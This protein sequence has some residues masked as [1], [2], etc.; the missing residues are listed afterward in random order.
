MIT[1]VGLIYLLIFL[2]VLSH[3]LAILQ[4]KDYW[5]GRILADP[6]VWQPHPS[7][8]L[9]VLTG[10]LLLW[11]RV[12]QIPIIATA[13]GLFL[14]LLIVQKLLTRQF[15]RPKPT[16]RIGLVASLVGLLTG[17]GYAISGNNPGS[18][19]IATGVCLWFVV[20]ANEVARHIVYIGHRRALSR[21]AKA[22]YS[23]PNIKVVGITGSFGKSTTKEFLNTILGQSHHYISTPGSINTD[24]GLATSLNQQF[25]ML[26]PH[27]KQQT[28]FAV[29]EMD[30]YVV[31][32]LARVTQYFPLDLGLITAINEQHLDTFGG[33]IAN[34]VEGNFQM[35]VG[36]NRSQPSLAVFNFDNEYCRAMADRFVNELQGEVYSYG[37]VGANL[38]VRVSEVKSIIAPGKQS[39][40]FKLEFSKRLGGEFISLELPVPN[41]F[42][43]VNYAAAALLAKLL[44]VN[45]ADIKA[46]ASK[47]TVKDRTQK[48]WLTS[49]GIEIIDDTFN[50][51]P[52]SVRANLE[53]LKQ[54]N[55]I[56]PARN[57]V[58]FT[59]LYD[60]GP[61]A[62]EIHQELGNRLEQVADVA[63]LTN[64]VWGEQ[65]K[66]GN[67]S[68][69]KLIVN[70][71][72][73][74]LLSDL[75]KELAKTTSANLPKLRI[76]MI[77]RIPAAVYKFIK[78]LN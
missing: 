28:E 22:L 68:S 12:P 46:A 76:L 30:A 74:S 64:P 50:A 7:D 33:D 62:K 9:L 60:L 55:E 48:I 13:I 21:A 25:A 47:V 75:Q 19:A 77:N 17:L 6:R 65:L 37:R 72:P 38:D 20:I 1:I 11:D 59:G 53:L 71:N 78:Q 54:R 18:L 67:A 35:L 61:K 39:L 52:A 10:L 32:T 15:K 31:G 3:K 23:I 34:T 29:L 41:E 51:N 49:S 57:I 5:R 26:K 63:Y 69:K 40:Q 70:S 14:L 8:I 27:E 16:L 24:I 44:G 58:I 45:N 73:D 66:V 2:A 36:I 4:E 42:N 56:L 43:A